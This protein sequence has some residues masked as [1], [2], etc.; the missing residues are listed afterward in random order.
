MDYEKDL[1]LPI[2]QSP[3]NAQHEF[4]LPHE[5]RATPFNSRDSILGKDLGLIIA[6]VSTKSTSQGIELGWANVADTPIA[7]IYKPNTKLPNSLKIVSKTFIEYANPEQ[8]IE[9]IEK[10][11]REIKH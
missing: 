10:A 9:G 11:I 1:Y 4:V 3:L 5:E 7:F 6:E 8:L 2:R